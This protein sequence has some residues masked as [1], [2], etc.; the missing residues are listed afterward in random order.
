MNRYYSGQMVTFSASFAIDGAPTD[1]GTAYFSIWHTA[2]GTVTYTYPAS[3]DVVRQGTG[4][5]TFNYTL[6]H[7]GEWRYY[8]RSTGDVHAASGYVLE[9]LG[10][11]P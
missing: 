1:P 4:Q 7:T 9:C 11:L 3:A 2:L 5:F 6:T 8:W 10:L